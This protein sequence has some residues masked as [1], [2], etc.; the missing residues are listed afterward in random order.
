MKN[1]AAWAAISLFLLVKL[2]NGKP[3]P[4]G[5]RND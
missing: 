1:L 4:E 3:K 2:I 5:K